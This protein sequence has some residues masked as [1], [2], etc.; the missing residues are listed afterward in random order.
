MLRAK[1][2]AKRQRLWDQSL[3]SL[4]AK[5]NVPLASLE[6]EQRWVL[7]AALQV[8]SVMQSTPV[9]HRVVG[10]FLLHCG[11]R[12][13]AAVVGAALSLGPRA[14]CALK[15][16]P[17]EGVLASLRRS[18]SGTK[19]KLRAQHVGRI[20]RFLMDHPDAT[21]PRCTS[22]LAASSASRSSGMRCGVSSVATVWES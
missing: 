10:F 15:H 12:L 6:P 11:L 18:R 4:Q 19:P 8:L 16:T 17:A 7:L 14:V 22:L 3:S 2:L 5:T 1:R 21:L 13:P 9:L 20:A